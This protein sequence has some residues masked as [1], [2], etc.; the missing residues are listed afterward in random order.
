MNDFIPA[1]WQLLLVF[2]A[3]G[4]VSFLG[5]MMLVV[6]GN[7]RRAR[8]EKEQQWRSYNGG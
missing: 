1:L 2:V 8:G 5:I 3:A 7:K 4:V 6:F